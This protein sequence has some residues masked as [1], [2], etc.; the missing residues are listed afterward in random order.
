M[1]IFKTDFLGIR[2]TASSIVFDFFFWKYVRL[3]PF[4]EYMGE[5]FWSKIIFFL[6]Y[7]CTYKLLCVVFSLV[8][9]ESSDFLYASFFPCIFTSSLFM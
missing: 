1:C 6:S 9:F 7:F 2:L 3:C 4:V 8:C 5:F